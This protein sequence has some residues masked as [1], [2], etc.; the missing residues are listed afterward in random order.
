MAQSAE[1]TH[2]GVV[3]SSQSD[4]NDHESG[5]QSSTLP[6][7]H[8]PESVPDDVMVSVSDLKVDFNSDPTAHCNADEMVTI[9]FSDAHE[10]K[11]AQTASD[12]G[13]VPPP[14]VGE[15]PLESD[16]QREDEK[17]VQNQEDHVEEL[18]KQTDNLNLE[19]MVSTSDEIVQQ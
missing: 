17:I 7:D 1:V 18:V 16:D 11:D 3:P 6:A 4:N 14:V 13:D 19:E 12:D 10:Q 2:D 9:G 8:H 15:P 5:D